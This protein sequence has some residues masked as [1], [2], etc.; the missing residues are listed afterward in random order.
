[1]LTRRGR[2]R[3]VAASMLVLLPVLSPDAS[4]ADHDRPGGTWETDSARLTQVVTEYEHHNPW[5]CSNPPTRTEFGT[6]I[7]DPCAWQNAYS[8]AAPYGTRQHSALRGGVVV[9]KCTLGFNQGPACGHSP[10]SPQ[11]TFAGSSHAIH[12][13]DT[14]LATGYVCSAAAGHGAL[15]QA[16][17]GLL[18]NSDGHPVGHNGPFC[19]TFTPDTATVSISGVTV[20]EGGRAVLTIT[21][22]GGSDDGYVDFATGN[23]SAVAP[24]DY[25]ATS[26][27][28][29]FSSSQL[30]KQV[31]VS[32]TDD[33]DVESTESFTVV[34]SN[35][36]DVNIG[37][38]TATATIIDNDTLATVNIAGATVTEGGVAELEVKLSGGNVAGTVDYATRNS[39]AVSPGDYT[40]TTGTLTFSPTVTSRRVRVTTI[41]DDDDEGTETF[42]VR[43]SNASNVSIGTAEATVHILDDD[44]PDP[45]LRCQAGEHAHN[46]VFGSGVHP[47]G[48]SGTDAHRVA[49]GGGSATGCFGDHPAPV[50]QPV[51][52]GCNAAGTRLSALSATAGTYTLS[53]FS[54]TTYSYALAVIGERSVQ[55]S[56]TAAGSGASVSIHGGGA[57]LGSASRSIYLS[58]YN[59]SFSVQ[60]TNSGESCTYTVN[61]SYQAAPLTSCPAMS[62][63]E[64]VNGVCVPA[65]SGNFI[66]QFDDNGQVNG[67]IFLGDCPFDL[68]GLDNPPTNPYR[69]YDPLWIAGPDTFPAVAEGESASLARTALKC[70]QVWREDPTGWPGW[71]NDVHRC[72]WNE[73]NLSSFGDCLSFSL[74]VEAVIPAVEADS[75]T[76]PW[77][78]KSDDCGLNASAPR[79]ESTTNPWTPDDT[80]CEPSAGVWTR[81]YCSGRCTPAP[82]TSDTGDWTVTLGDL[83]NPSAYGPYVDVPLEVSITDWGDASHL[84]VTATATKRDARWWF[85][86]ASDWG[87][88]PVWGTSASTSIVVPRRSGPPP[89]DD[90]IEVNVAEVSE[91][92]YATGTRCYQGHCRTYIEN[93]QFVNILR[94]E[95]LANDACPVGV[96]CS[97][98]NQWPVEIAGDSATRCNRRAFRHTTSR[99]AMQPTTQ[100]L[101]G[102]DDLNDTANPNDPASVQYWPQLWAAGQDTFTYTTYGGTATVTVNFTDQP[103][104]AADVTVHDPGVGHTV[105]A[106]DDPTDRSV[107]F[108]RTWNSNAGYCTL[109]AYNYYADYS[110]TAS[111]WSA[112]HHAG[113][114]LL[115]SVRDSDPDDDTASII[116][117][118]GNNPHLTGRSGIVAAANYSQWETDKTTEWTYTGSCWPNPCPPPANRFA[119]FIRGG[120]TGGH[121]PVNPADGTRPTS[122]SLCVADADTTLTS[123]ITYIQW[124][125]NSYP[126]EVTRWSAPVDADPACVPSIPDGCSDASMLVDWSMCYALWP[127][128]T[129]PAPLV[130]DYRACDERL[131]AFESDRTN[132]EAT[133]RTAADYCSDG[134]VTVLLGDSSTVSLQPSASSATEGARLQFE[135]V[136]DTPAAVDVAVSLSVMPDTTGTDPAEPSDYDT[137]S[138]PG[139]RAVL[140]PVTIPAGQDRTTVQVCTVQDSIHEN[141]ETL[142]LEITSATGARLG[143]VIQAVGTIVN[144]D[145]LPQV[146]VADVSAGEDISIPLNPPFDIDGDGIPDTEYVYGDTMRFTVTL[147][148]ESDRPITVSYDTE[149]TAGTATSVTYCQSYPGSAAEDYRPKSG[150]LT[151]TPGDTS[152][153]FA[154]ILCPD[155]QYEGN[156]TLIVTLSSP[157]NATLGTPSATGTIVDNDVPPLTLLQQCELLHG[158]GWAPVLYPDDTPW[159]DSFG[160]I[161][162]AMPH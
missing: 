93:D 30:S 48:V 100:G 107:R 126:S 97:D 118:D 86:S 88:D 132:A 134:A 57:S 32:T 98:P 46:P 50:V 141:D 101:V 71:P 60:V 105:A 76:R 127:N 139:C 58:S 129:N 4:F 121:R 67:C 25:T 27:R 156:E 72:I 39:T 82:T 110:R 131:E 113:S 37:T 56:A 49:H 122:I 10:A 92:R 143:T 162:C 153:T 147:V 137:S 5:V 9:T 81:S 96:D 19:G 120:Y 135:V 61:V 80:V 85:N 42:T 1:M 116:I 7:E 70:F 12:L 18:Y 133:G 45:P 3:L 89:S 54:P 95:L 68:Y 109:Y 111:D 128:A 66:P 158:P 157:T 145:P 144:D 21:S 140:L 16:S 117:T 15:Y 13:D 28:H 102:C 112:T 23:G 29:T 142:L 6:I 20:T 103:P 24:G 125:W 38:G 53:G 36:Q 52:T 161:V 91:L 138:D 79:V 2:W 51:Q 75:A 43:L 119:D 115:S 84:V 148:G 149:T 34:L 8:P 150:T 40:T 83:T 41:D 74:T 63:Q 11:W 114:V 44:D 106:F 123:T 159:T 78:F 77:S 87:Y 146:T 31:I 17:F 151:F 94:S 73:L 65:C 64:L 35:P 62:G 104:D 152:E 47:P 155:D 90:I 22:S 160:Q 26:G 108:C 69:D 154:V 124:Y 55:V 14:T 59:M 136:L 99:S 33:S 130:V